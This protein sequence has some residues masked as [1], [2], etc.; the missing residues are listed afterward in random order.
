MGCI[1]SKRG[2][3]NDGLKDCDSENILISCSASMSN[4]DPIL[5][6]VVSM[7]F[8]SAVVAFLSE[9]TN[10]EREPIIRLGG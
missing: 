9:K 3:V 10:C 5:S 4:W 2:G 7:S 6:I 1:L 8:S